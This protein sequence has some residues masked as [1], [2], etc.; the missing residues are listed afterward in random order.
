VSLLLLFHTSE[1]QSEYPSIPE[2]A[3][4]DAQILTLITCD[5]LQVDFGA[6]LLSVSDVLVEDI[7][8]DL[9]GGEVEHS[10]Y[11]DVHGTC[12]LQLSRALTWSTARLRLSQ[13]LTGAGLTKTWYLGV[14][15]PLTP[16]TPLGETPATYD[17]QG[18]DKLHL[19]QKPIGD[20]YVVAT[21]TGYLAAV[22]T[23][24]TA[25]GDTGLAPLLDGTQEAAVLPAPMVWILD[26]ADLT[27]YLRVINDLLAVV[28]YRGLYADRNG[29]YCSE[30]Y[31]SPID[32]PSIW[33]LDLSDA[34]TCIVGEYRTMTTDEWD[35]SNWWRFVRTGMAAQPVE[36]T[37]LY[38]VDQSGGG[39]KHKRIVALD[40]ADQAALVLRGDAIVQSQTQLDRTLEITT[41]PLP[42][43]GHFDVM[44]YRDPAAVGELKTQV[45]SW[46]LPLDGADCSL[47]LEV[48]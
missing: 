41:G 44:L 38:T 2:V 21:G 22:R 27:S 18:Y 13:T 29:R 31:H 30:P 9:L 12:S 35:G 46:R 3:L 4:T 34:H 14:Y 43:M 32:R 15:L 20:T 19:L 39:T 17:V 24:I 16:Q 42:I 7:S 5:N 26:P 28:G 45:R 33:T 6:E 1:A 36:G 47:T 48:L 23:A 40:V 8:D 11:A 25:S 10:N 37:G